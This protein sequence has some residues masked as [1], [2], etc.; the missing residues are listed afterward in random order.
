MLFEMILFWLYIETGQIQSIRCAGVRACG[1]V[2][3]LCGRARHRGLVQDGQERPAEHVQCDQ[4]AD[5]CHSARRRAVRD[6]ND[7]KVVRSRF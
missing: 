6:E 3:G 1:R 5:E 2:G 4:V 7:A